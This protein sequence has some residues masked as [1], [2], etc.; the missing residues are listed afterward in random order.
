MMMRVSYGQI[1]SS[2]GLIRF[3]RQSIEEV[4]CGGS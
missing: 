2:F 1:A 3:Y 4:P